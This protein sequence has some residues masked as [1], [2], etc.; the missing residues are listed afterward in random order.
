II[1]FS[2][3]L[4]IFG[5]THFAF[6]DSPSSFIFILLTA[7]AITKHNLMDISVILKKSASIVITGSIIVTTFILIYLGTQPIPILQLVATTLFVLAASFFAIPLQTKLITSAK[8]AFVKGYYESDKVLNH[9]SSLFKAET[10]QRTMFLTL[11]YAL[12]E[13]INF[14]K[15]HLVIGRRVEDE[16]LGHFELINYMSNSKTRE[17]GP[18]KISDTALTLF[19][20]YSD[21]VMYKEL[22]ADQQKEVAQW[23]ADAKSIVLP[24]SSPEGLEGLIVLG[25][26]SNGKVYTEKDIK[27][28]NSVIA[29][30]SAFLYKLTPYEKLQTEFMRTKQQLIEQDKALAR[31]EKIASLAR[32]IQEYNHEIKTPLSILGLTVRRLKS[33]D[34]L[35]AFKADMNQLIARA[36]DIVETTLRISKPREHRDVPVNLVEVLETALH[37]FPPDGVQLIKQFE[38]VPNMMGDPDDLHILFTNL[39]KNAYEAMENGGTLTVHAFAETD[40]YATYARVDVSDTGTGIAPE[41]IERI[42]DPFF[43]THVTKGRGLGLSLA[44]RIAREHL[45]SIQIESALGQGSTFKVQLKA[46]SG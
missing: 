1:I 23:G 18:I 34:D 12:D 41:N 36:N 30:M 14:D 20:S 25:E 22:D 24:L 19:G 44:F 15:I 7:Y 33:G 10:D 16:Q 37:Q 45:G 6:L 9:I 8:K 43:S 5:N 2:L 27:F 13:A 21:S 28:F 11:A 38:T 31:T 4:P 29:V 32:V 3:V 35:E 17:L 39:F 26:R 46:K 42:W 40:N